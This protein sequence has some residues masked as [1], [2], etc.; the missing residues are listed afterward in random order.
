MQ[1]EATGRENILFQGVW[2]GWRRAT[3]RAKSDEIIEFAQIGDFIDWGVYVKLLSPN[4]QQF[5][6]TVQGLEGY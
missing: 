1:L 2:L 6:Q 4:G 3:M 5:G